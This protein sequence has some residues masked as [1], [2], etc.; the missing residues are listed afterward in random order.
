MRVWKNKIIFLEHFKEKWQQLHAANPALPSLC[1][2]PGEETGD[3][4]LPK[5]ANVPIPVPRTALPGHPLSPLATPQTHSEHTETLSFRNAKS[6]FC[7]SPEP[8]F[9]SRWH[10]IR[11][12]IGY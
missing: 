4:P 9:H 6:V 11:V 5:A 10:V 12:L 8:S 2:Q 1:I 7:F 3:L